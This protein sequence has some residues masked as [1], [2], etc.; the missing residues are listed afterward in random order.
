MPMIQID[1]WPDGLPAGHPANAATRRE[2]VEGTIELRL[3]HVD[4]R[5]RPAMLVCPGGGYGFRSP[6]ER[7][8]VAGW[9]NG[10]G[11]HAVIVEY[12]CDRWH[13]PAP[14]QDA[15]RALRLVRQRA[16]DWGIDPERVGILGFSA[17][18]HLAASLA[19]HHDL[20]SPEAAD[21]IEQQSCR[22]DLAVLCYPVIS[23]L[24]AAHAGSCDR[25]LGPAAD[26]E[27]AAYLS[28]ERQVQADTP[29][30]FLWH[31]ADDAVVPVVHS[32]RFAEAC[33]RAEVPCALHVYPN[34]AH[35]L[36]LATADPV[37]GEWT[38]SCA[39]WL[40]QADWLSS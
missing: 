8:N 32:L 7:D 24:E 28:L 6:R 38:S 11:L 26:T 25:L 12:R 19:C 2:G 40:Q 3:V 14:L 15:A 29:P 9:L 4:E 37:V 5:P 33:A 20:G 13:H 35:G 10:L 18:G 31:T 23:M 30:C 16:G 21:P 1:L 22:P 34:G 39:R 36:N 17:G 27:L